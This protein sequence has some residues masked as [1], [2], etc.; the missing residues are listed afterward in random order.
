MQKSSKRASEKLII[1]TANFGLSYGIACG[2]KLPKEEIKQILSLAK[3]SG[4]Y[5]VDTA[6]AYGEALEILGELLSEEFLIIS[7]LAPKSKEELLED[8]KL[9]LKKLRRRRVDYLLLHKPSLVKEKGVVD[10]L[11]R[12]LEEGL[13]KSVGVSV[14]HSWEVELF[15]EY[16]ESFSVEL[17]LSVYDQRFKK[18]LDTYVKMGLEVF[19][20]SVFLQGAVFL[21]SLPPWLEALSKPNE[22]LREIANNLGISLEC[23]CLGFV[24][25]H[26]QLSGIVIGVDSVFQLKK[27]LDC[28]ELDID[29]SEFAQTDERLILPYLWEG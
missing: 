6:K 14:Y 15:S 20:R 16:F 9:S 28:K 26:S 2:K 23:L 7:K 1:G 27:N 12:A 18:E 8:L 22:R 10:G 5:R 17:P 11:Y 24:L 19:A 29:L 3:A 25:S 21:K 13:V 4:I